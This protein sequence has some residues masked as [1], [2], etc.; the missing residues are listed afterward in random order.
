MLE[1][2]YEHDHGDEHGD[3]DD[4]NDDNGDKDDDND[5]Q[6]SFDCVAMNG[7]PAANP[8]EVRQTLFLLVHRE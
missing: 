2:D 8:V 6:T 5:N 3:D 1:G 4:S 7:I